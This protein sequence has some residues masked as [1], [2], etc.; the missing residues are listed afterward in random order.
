MSGDKPILIKGI[1]ISDYDPSIIIENTMKKLNDRNLNIS[2]VDMLHV[3]HSF[4]SECVRGKD[5]DDI[6]AIDAVPESFQVLFF[7]EKEQKALAE[8]DSFDIPIVIGID[9]DPE[10]RKYNAESW[11]RKLNDKKG[12]DNNV[13]I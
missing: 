1:N 2:Q 4:I 13:S 12:S 5:E 3:I 9:F 8:G 10:K 11:K 7:G 6:I